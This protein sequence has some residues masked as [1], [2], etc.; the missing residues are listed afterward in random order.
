M[1]SIIHGSYQ[2]FIILDHHHMLFFKV[3]VSIIHQ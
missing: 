2:R 1:L 3:F